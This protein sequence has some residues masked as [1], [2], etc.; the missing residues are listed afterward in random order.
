MQL[1]HRDLHDGNVICS[2]DQVVG[3][4]DC[5][6]F[7]FGT[8]MIDIAYFLHNTVKWIGEVDGTRVKNEGDKIWWLS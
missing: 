5:D 2:G 6:H 1:I 7:S 3:I 8:P 4:V